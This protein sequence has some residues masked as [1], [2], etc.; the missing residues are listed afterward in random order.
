MA[1]NGTGFRWT[2]QRDQ[3][4]QLVAE[5]SLTDEAI[6]SE[7]GVSRRQLA[8]WKCDGEFAARVE[9]IRKT[10]GDLALRH[11]IS[12]RHRRVRALDERWE[13]LQRVIAERGAAKE[14]AKVPG[15]RTGL[16]VRTV[17]GLGTG[18]NFRTV[19]E[20]EVDTGLLRELREHEKQAAQEL[21]Q[22][23]EKR[24]LTGA[25]GGPVPISI[26]E[27]VDA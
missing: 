8:R 25:D 11:V 1:Q 23:S 22:W 5:D 7:V 17:K 15:G 14:M 21:G 9:E 10:L 2:P 12:K 4:A 24:E 13:K 6:A 16:L 3:A 18:D 20:Y 27:F 26:V 19:E